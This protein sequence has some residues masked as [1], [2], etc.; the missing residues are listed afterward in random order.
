MIKELCVL[1]QIVSCPVLEVVQDSKEPW[2]EYWISE[3]KI[4][5]NS[6]D[7]NLLVHELAHAKVRETYDYYVDSHGKE[8]Q[9]L[10]ERYEDPNGSD[11]S[12]QC[13]YYKKCRD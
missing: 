4:V 7:R 2:G 8:W 10:Y 3:N 9:E 12:F 13:G 6:L 11:F 5:V 1:M